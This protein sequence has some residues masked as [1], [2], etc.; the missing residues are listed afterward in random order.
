MDLDWAFATAIFVFFI[1]WSFLYFYSII[2]AYSQ[3]NEEHMRHFSEIIRDKLMIEGYEIP[4][5]FNSTQ[6]RDNSVFYATLL[7]NS[8]YKSTLRVEKNDQLQE[9]IVSG[10]NIYWISNV[11]KGINYFTIKYAETITA[12]VCSGTFTIENETMLIPWAQ[13][14]RDMFSNT[15]LTELL[16]TDYE[17]FKAD[18]GI[19]NDFRVI[20]E[21]SEGVYEYGRSLPQATDTYTFF[22]SAK[23]YED[24]E[25]VNITIYMW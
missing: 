24:D 16:S 8:T 25:R 6:N 22:Y 3:I 15:S 23:R 9:C 18:N 2:P 11:S 1:S 5:S 10:D 14:M 21:A 13:K 20:I 7:L 12:P 19:T 17:S 4:V